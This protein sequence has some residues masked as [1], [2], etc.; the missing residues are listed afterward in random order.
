MNLKDETV[1]RR[2]D[3]NHHTV[4]VQNNK[5]IEVTSHYDKDYRT[6]AFISGEPFSCDYDI[7]MSEIIENLDTSLCNIDSNESPHTNISTN[8]NN[9]TSTVDVRVSIDITTS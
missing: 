4:N 8:G 1:A 5:L 7:D 3:F 9:I 6:A 2:K